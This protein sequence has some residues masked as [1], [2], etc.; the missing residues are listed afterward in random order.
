MILKARWAEI[1]KLHRTGRTN[2]EIAEDLGVARST[3]G[4]AL[5]SMWERH[6]RTCRCGG[7]IEYG[8]NPDEPRHYHRCANCAAKEWNATLRQRWMEA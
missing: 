8:L 6:K 4:R 1:R 5:A 3:V 2:R 7:L